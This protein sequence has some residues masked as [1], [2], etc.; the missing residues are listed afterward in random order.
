MHARTQKHTSGTR[1]RRFFFFYT[2]FFQSHLRVTTTAHDCVHRAPEHTFVSTKSA[3]S[4]KN[5]V[6]NCRAGPRPSRPL[7]RSTRVSI[8]HRAH[9]HDGVW[10]RGWPSCG[11]PVERGAKLACTGKGCR[12]PLIAAGLFVKNCSRGT[13]RRTLG[14]AAAGVYFKS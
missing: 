12:G 2:N 1:A 6:G 14:A 3:T 13:R 11:R 4:R 8:G 7:R 5:D 10:R 9:V